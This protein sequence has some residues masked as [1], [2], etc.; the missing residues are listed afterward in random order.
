MPYLA[1]LV[2]EGLP[3]EADDLGEGGVV[4]LDGG[5]DVLVADEGRAEED[6]RVGRARDVPRGPAGAVVRVGGL[7]RAGCGGARG[8]IGAGGS[9]LGGSG[10]AGGGGAGGGT[11]RGGGAVAGAS[12][13]WRGSARGEEDGPW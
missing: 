9:A 12:A 11:G 10:S 3:G 6:E 13:G 1:L 5:G 4:G 7:V 2:G 8:G